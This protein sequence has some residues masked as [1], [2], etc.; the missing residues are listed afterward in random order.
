MRVVDSMQHRRFLL[1]MK[2]IS[3]LVW[4]VRRL[5]GFSCRFEGIFA[6]STTIS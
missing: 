4:E 1:V 5:G 6:F 2:F 3:V